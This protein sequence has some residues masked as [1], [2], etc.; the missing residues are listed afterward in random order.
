[1]K[2]PLLPP[3]GVVVITVGEARAKF[4][5][6][7]G[8][9]LPAWGDSPAIPRDPDDY[10]CWILDGGA[11]IRTRFKTP[12]SALENAW[13]ILWWAYETWGS[14]KEKRQILMDKIEILQKRGHGFPKT[15]QGIR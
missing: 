12:E 7:I 5:P 1:M 2:S 11:D 9:A 8:A 13:E 4:N 14:E 10:W 6:D 15:Y 3:P